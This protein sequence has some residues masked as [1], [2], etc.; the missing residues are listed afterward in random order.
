MKTIKSILVGVMAVVAMFVAAPKVQAQT[1][2][3][4]RKM[5]VAEMRKELPMEVEEGLTWS[6]CDLSQ[7]GETMIWTF[8]INPR[9]MGV[10]LADAKEEFNGLTSREFKAMI[11]E[12]GEFD[13]IMG[14]LGCDVQIIIAFPDGTNKKFMLRR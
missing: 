10:S 3:E 1:A 12:D 7:D 11:D 13:S 14:M 8:K 4:M 6:K 2:L 9:K 5:V